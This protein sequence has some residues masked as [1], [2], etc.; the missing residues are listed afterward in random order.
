MAGATSSADTAGL[1]TFSGETEDSREYKRWKTWVSNK[2]LTLE[3]KIPAAAQGAYV[4]TLLSGKALEAVEHLDASEYQVD[5]GDQVLFRILDARF[6]QKDASDEMSE[7]L[8]EVFALRATEGET[9]K[10]WISRASELFDRCGRKCKV[11]FP[12]EVRGWMLLNRVGF[13]EEQKAVILARSGGVLKREE[14][15]RAMRSCYP[16]YVVKKKNIGISLVESPELE[17]FEPADEFDPLDAEV[18]AFLADHIESP[19][20][21]DPEEIYEEHEVA[22]VLAVSWKEKRRELTKLQRARKFGAAN[23][24]RRAYRVEIEELKKKTK[25]HKCLQVGHWSRECKAKGKGKGK[26]S[27]GKSS[28]TGAALVQETQEDFVAM[29]ECFQVSPLDLLRQRRASRSQPSLSSSSTLLSSSSDSESSDEVLLV[30]SPGF[31]V[32]DSGCGRTIIGQDTLS[33]FAELWKA[34]G[35]PYPETIS[36]VNHFKYGNGH[37]ETTHE[38]VRL[39]VMIA[40]KSGTIKAAVVKG[41]APLLVSRSALKTLK[42]V[43]DCETDEMTLFQERIKVPLSTNAAGQYIIR[44]VS[45]DFKPKK[46]EPEFSEVMLSQNS[47]AMS[48]SASDDTT[49]PSDRSGSSS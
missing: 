44:V 49:A 46:K 39:P 27:G 8:T 40:G 37:R 11:N 42:A 43:I 19:D 4:Y 10:T 32:I 3:S 26:S 1:K 15:G 33:E 12:E 38:S 17:H 36:E 22:E 34:Q 25:C 24:L 31:G 6:P 20:S 48:T 14:I 21:A 47:P 41:Q 13:T 18:E 23:D 7:T 35:I 30:S 29:V 9:L 5:G 2:L 28:D 16:E 45:S